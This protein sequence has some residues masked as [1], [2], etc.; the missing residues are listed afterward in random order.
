MN[1]YRPVSLQAFLIEEYFFTHEISTE[2]SI[3]DLENISDDDLINDLGDPTIC[4]T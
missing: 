2:S 4:L 1:I 3:D